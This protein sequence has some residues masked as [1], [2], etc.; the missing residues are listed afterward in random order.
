MDPSS[1][2][3]SSSV[4]SWGPWG[5]LFHVI[6]GAFVLGG[7]A[8]LPTGLP[9]CPWP[10]SRRTPVALGRSPPVPGQRRGRSD[11]SPETPSV[12]F[13]SNSDPSGVPRGA[14]NLKHKYNALMF[15]NFL[16]G[17]L[18]ASRTSRARLRATF[19]T[20][21]AP[22]EPSVGTVGVL[23]V[24]SGA[25]VDVWVD[26]SCIRWYLRDMPMPLKRNPG[27]TAQK[28]PKSGGSQSEAVICQ[29]N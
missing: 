6:S 28:I 3:R 9:R 17:P 14:P 27:H 12:A 26:L 18:R 16:C 10:T 11:F 2:F 4:Q 19:G 1:A 25:F 8:F 21:K 13:G 20:T 24:L 7:F 15:L 22:A 29:L 23:R 5:S